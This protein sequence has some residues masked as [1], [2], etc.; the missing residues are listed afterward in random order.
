MSQLH[1]KDLKY[2]RYNGCNTRASFNLPHIKKR[3]F[4]SIHKGL[5][6]IDI[7]KPLCNHKD[8]KV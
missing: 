1:H 6:M 7:T 8:C 3:L 2:C 5:G 4:C